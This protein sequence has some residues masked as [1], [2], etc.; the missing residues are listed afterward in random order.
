MI[1]KEEFQILQDIYQEKSLT[2]LLLYGQPGCGKTYLVRQFMKDKKGFYFKCLSQHYPV[3]V[4]RFIRVV[5][6]QYPE[7]ES[8]NNWEEFIPKVYDL[9]KKENL[10]VIWDDFPFLYK[11]TQDVLTV[12]EKNSVDSPFTVFVTSSF[13]QANFVD[14]RF[15][16][17]SKKNFTSLQIKPLSFK[18][19]KNYYKDLKPI[20]AIEF[21]GITGGVARFMEWIDPKMDFYENIKENF[22]SEKRLPFYDPTSILRY[23]FHEPSTYYS[24]IQVLAYHQLKIGDLSHKL[25]LQTHNLTSFVDRLRE[26]KMISRMVPG[27]STNPKVTRKSRYMISDV[28]LYFWFRYV[29]YDPEAIFTLNTDIIIEHIK[30]DYQ[31][32]I[33]HVLQEIVKQHFST[34]ETNFTPIVTSSWWDYDGHELDLVSTDYKKVLYGDIVFNDEL[35]DLEKYSEFMDSI[36]FVPF[37]NKIKQKYYYIISR[38]GFSPELRRRLKVKKTVKLLTVEEFVDLI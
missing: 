30:E 27:N 12:I 25:N 28:F 5:Q 11:I 9:A 3:Q 21:Y 20:Q 8:V 36:E 13:P 14:F 6:R 15:S 38:K 26:M 34:L 4:S 22:I 35:Y 29:Y 23:E 19:F 24:I 31:N 7:F 1:H 32:F 16:T 33:D 18:E 2:M 37:K 10:V 17:F